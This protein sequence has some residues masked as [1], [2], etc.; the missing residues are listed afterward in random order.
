L[1][2]YLDF[3]GKYSLPEAKSERVRLFYEK[4]KEKKQTVAQRE[5]AA[6]AIMLFFETGSVTSVI[7]EE[8]AVR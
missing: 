7:F 8:E 4:L 5:R 6:L 2:Y 1:R 3:S